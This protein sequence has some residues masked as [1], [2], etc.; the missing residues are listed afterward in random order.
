MSATIVEGYTISSPSIVA[1]E[2]A[3]ETLER[4]E[5]S[6]LKQDEVQITLEW[7]ASKYVFDACWSDVSQAIEV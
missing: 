2:H 6:E 1:S 4:N 3:A 5:A 7:L